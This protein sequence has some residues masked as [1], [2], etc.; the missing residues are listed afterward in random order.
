MDILTSLQKK[1]KELLWNI[2]YHLIYKKFHLLA[3]LLQSIDYFN[4]NHILEIRLIFM[5]WMKYNEV[6]EL[7]I[8]QLIS[9]LHY[10]YPDLFIRNYIVKLLTDMLTDYDL[11]IHLLQL[12]QCLKY[13]SY[14]HNTLSRFLIQRALLSPISIGHLFFWLLKSELH[15]LKWNERFS[16][17]IEEYL[18]FSNKHSS[19]LRIQNTACN[20][21]CT[22]SKNIIKLTRQNTPEDIIKEQYKQSLESFNDNFLIPNG[23]M[24]LPTDPKRKVIKLCI[25][26][27]RYM[28]SKM[29][30]LWLVFE[31]ADG[32]S[33]DATT[34]ETNNNPSSQLPPIYVMFKAGDDLK[35]DMLTLQL[36]NIM[37][38]IWLNE[39]LDL[40]LSTYEVIATGN[41]VGM[42]EP[43]INS[44]TIS[45]IQVKYGG[46]A[47]GALKEDP[48]DLFIK[49]YNIGKQNY[50]NA[51][52]N[53]TR[54]SA[55]YLVATY[56]LGI[57]DRH[58]GNIMITKQGHLFHIDFGH[59]LGNFKSKFGVNRER[60]AFVFTTEMAYVMGGYKSKLFKNFL[61]LCSAAYASLR[62]N[63]TQFQVLLQ[64]MV[65]ARMPELLIDDD[66]QYF[67]N[68]MYLHKNNEIA[69][70]YLRNEIKK[71]LKNNYKKLDDLLHNIRHA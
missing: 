17:Y 10:K 71:S 12:V 8:S 6:K 45:G 51:V 30:P 69:D 22:I 66:I 58:N 42:I 46:G 57:G 40:R 34:T 41:E 67:T 59:I 65:A 70:K 63:T 38:N 14:H 47:M 62:N 35:Q 60:A 25:N 26:K 61:N 68:K 37:D 53:F 4:I 3:K 54:S 49:D 15:V 18:A 29:V 44:D 27:C 23:G 21:L 36:L 55:G 11:K 39:G 13:E 20:K 19:L 31:N 5:S 56:I 16:L 28:S 9:L 32:Y 7:Q 48:L 2:R 52:D 64:L 1:H 24:Y 43:V 33:N 50:E